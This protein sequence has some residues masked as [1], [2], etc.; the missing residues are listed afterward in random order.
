MTSKDF[1]DPVTKTM[2]WDSI[3][4]FRSLVNPTPANARGRTLLGG[5]LRYGYLPPFFE[6]ISSHQ[7][8][9]QDSG[10][11]IGKI[12]KNHLIRNY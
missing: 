5:W 6:T 8:Q 4:T 9:R 2:E 10:E 7:D 11:Q 12:A 1:A 3:Q